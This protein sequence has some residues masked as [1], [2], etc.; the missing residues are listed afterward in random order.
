MAMAEEYRP[1][2]NV[3]LTPAE[4]KASQQRALA[5]EAEGEKRAATGM[6]SPGY[7]HYGDLVYVRGEMLPEEVAQALLEQ[8]PELD[9]GVFKVKPIG[10]RKPPKEVT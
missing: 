1:G 8:Q 4:L 6:T 3:P 5:A 7:I 9:Q 2:A 10:R